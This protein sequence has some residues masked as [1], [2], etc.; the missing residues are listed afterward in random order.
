MTTEEA[1]YKICPIF[2]SDQKYCK[3]DGC[4]SWEF[5]NIEKKTGFCRIIVRRI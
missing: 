2:N 1:K 4:M 5:Y 3:A